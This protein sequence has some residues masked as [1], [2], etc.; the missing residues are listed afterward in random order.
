MIGAVAGGHERARR[1]V[2]NG[3]A[4]PTTITGYWRRPQASSAS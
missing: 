3:D 4:S 2:R 1:G